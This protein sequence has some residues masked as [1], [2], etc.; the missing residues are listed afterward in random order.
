[1]SRRVVSAKRFDHVSDKLDPDRFQIA[2]GE[3][4]DYAAANGE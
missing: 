3:D 2:G 1:L 4:V